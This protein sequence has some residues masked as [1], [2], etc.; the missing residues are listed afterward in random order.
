M[1]LWAEHFVRKPLQGAATDVNSRWR[2]A[3][4]GVAGGLGVALK[5]LDV[6]AAKSAAHIGRMRLWRHVL[7]GREIAGY[8]AGKEHLAPAEHQ[9]GL[10]E[11]R[12]RRRCRLLTG[13]LR[14]NWVVAFVTW[15]FP[16]RTIVA[17]IQN[18]C[19]L[20]QQYADSGEDARG[21]LPVM[22]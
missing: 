8:R 15:R 19:A 3:G 9:A 16:L 4:G 6:R 18:N 22:L 13:E 12:R 7:G 17:P 10:L 5:S 2:T 11:S 1:L 14:S 21:V 20:L